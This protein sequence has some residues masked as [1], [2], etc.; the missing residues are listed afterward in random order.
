MAPNSRGTAVAQVY[1]IIALFVALLLGLV[2]LFQFQMDASVAMRVYAGGEGLWAKAQKDAVLS[3]E[4]YSISRDEADYQAYR[5]WIQVPLGDQQARLELQQPHPNLDVARAGYLQGRIHPGDIDYAIP[6]F[7]RFQHAAPM[8]AVIGH[9]TAADRLIAELIEV[10]DALHDEIVSGR[11]SPEAIRTIRARLEAINRAVTHEEDQF[12][13]TLAEASRWAN[14]LSRRLSYAIALLF[15]VLGIALSWP[16]ITRIRR[17]ESALVESEKRFRNLAESTSDWIWQV[18]ECGVYVYSSAKIHDLLG[19]DPEEVCGKTPFDFMPP[20]EAARVGEIFKNIAGDRRPFSFL[21]NVNLHKDGHRVVLET[22]GVPLVGDDGIFHGYYGVERDITERKRVEDALRESEQRLRAV[23]EATVDGI[24]VADVQS[25]Q[26]VMGNRAIGDMLGYPPEELYR[27]GVADIHPPEALLDVQRQFERQL[28]GEIRVAPN[29]PVKRQDGSVFFADVSSAPMVLAERTCLV[30]VFHDVTGRREAEEAIRRLNEGLEEKVQER[31]QQLLAA[32]DELV[33]QEKLA[34]LG[35]VA[36]SVGHELRNPLGVM[37]NAVYFLQTV[38]AEADASVKE[39]L[40]MIK[41]EIT[42]AERIVSDL[43]DSVRTNP[44]HPEMVPVGELIGQTLRKLSVPAGVTVE[45]NLPATL[46]PLQV[47]PLQV[48]QVLRNLVSNAIDAMAEGGT[49][50]IRA[51]EA[52]AGK[53]V[54]IS[55]R[56]SGCGMTPEQL[57]RLFQPLFT[58]KARGIGLGLVV[59]K[60]L[61]EANGGSVTV[62]SKPGAGTTFTITLPSG[63]PEKVAAV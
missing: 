21:E 17:T 5:R 24:L 9:W 48:Q 7:R 39:Y 12:S 50:E 25:G 55:V 34:V 19:Y 4:Q 53:A 11:A 60:N 28:K 56:D 13:F 14:E 22:S 61:S 29:L 3:L 41:D 49:L 6:F 20:E 59:V 2:W 27:I 58:T 26:F 8:A 36:G 51:T 57:G 35:Q 37:N 40:D 62:Q 15:A 47:D 46:P 10:A 33:R 16:I 42:V 18:D 54:A 52:A 30:G 31:T 23:L 32:Q 1:L 45:L 44:P 38:L 63:F 43:L